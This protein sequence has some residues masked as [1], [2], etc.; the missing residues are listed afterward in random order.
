MKYPKHI[1]EPI[2]YEVACSIIS[3]ELKKVFSEFTKEE[4]QKLEKQIYGWAKDPEKHSLTKEPRDFW[5]AV[6]GIMTGFRIKGV[7]KFITAENVTWE[8]EELDPRK[9]H[10]V[11]DHFFINDEKIPTLNK[12]SKEVVAW[13]KTKGYEEM[14][15]EKVEKAFSVDPPRDKDPIYCKKDS[16]GE[17]YVHDGNGRVILALLQKRNMIPSY[18]GVQNG[19]KPINY[20]I[21][22]ILLVRYSQ[23]FSD[24]VIDESTYKRIITSS[25]AVSECAKIE[26]AERVPDKETLKA[27]ILTT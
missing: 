22:T 24:N 8:K 3:H 4:Y 15:L 7:V 26:Y 17:Y 5:N 2:R 14:A 20:W 11:T 6:E 1:Y 19:E 27:Q 10:F 13:L 21:S 12:S 18:V 25:F 23:L 9:L 16:K